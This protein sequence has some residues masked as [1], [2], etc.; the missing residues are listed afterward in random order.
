MAQLTNDFALRPNGFFSP[1]GGYPAFVKARSYCFRCAAFFVSMV[2]AAAAKSTPTA[3][4]SGNAFNALVMLAAHPSH[5]R[6]W[7]T[8]VSFIFF[9][10]NGSLRLAVVDKFFGAFYTKKI[11]LKKFGTKMRANRKACQRSQLCPPVIYI[12]LVSMANHEFRTPLT[13]IASSGAPYP[14]LNHP[15]P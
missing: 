13:R 9:Y 6:F 10:L 5:F 1:A 7:I 8:I 14:D 3:S 2:T 11:L 4:T 12:K 15:V